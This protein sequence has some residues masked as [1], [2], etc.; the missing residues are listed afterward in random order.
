MNTS[1]VVSKPNMLQINIVADQFTKG[2]AVER[3]E[4]WPGR[5][6]WSIEYQPKLSYGTA[7]GGTD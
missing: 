3:T 1:S 5:H 7:S 4:K 6:A 2:L